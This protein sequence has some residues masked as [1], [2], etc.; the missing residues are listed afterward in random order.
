[1]KTR[2]SILKIIRRNKFVNKI[3][4]NL[5]KFSFRK[6]SKVRTFL[7]NRWPTSGI[8]ECNFEEYQFK[9]FNQCDDGLVNHFYYGIPF[10][11]S[12]DL[13]LF[14]ILSKKSNTILDIGANTGLFSIL[15]HKA[16]PGSIIH[17]FEPYA[18]NADRLKKNLL[19]NSSQNVFVHEIAIGEKTETIQLTIPENGTITDVSSLN[20]SFSRAIYPELSWKNVDVL[21]KTLDQFIDENSLSIDLIKCDVETFE[22]SVFKGAKQ[23]L[24]EQKPTIL[25]ECFLDE[26]RLIFFNS[27]LK[28]YNY[29][30]YVIKDSGIEYVSEGF[31]QVSNGLNFIITP[32]KPEKSFIP[33]TDEAGICV[34]LL[35]TTIQ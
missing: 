26:E 11:E 12:N 31:K 2:V 5:I 15:A 13:K 8:T 24:K 35:K 4:R 29:Y 27:I 19:I 10:H 34:C 17:A 22:M 6:S 18:T 28:D 32:I 7:I 16:N 3:V 33:Y 23:L 1:M 14:L 25:F 20:A 21:C 9:F 30:L